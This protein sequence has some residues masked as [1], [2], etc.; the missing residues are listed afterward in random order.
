MNITYEGF[1]LMDRKRVNFYMAFYFSL[2]D[3]KMGC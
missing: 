1:Q 3:L 2:L